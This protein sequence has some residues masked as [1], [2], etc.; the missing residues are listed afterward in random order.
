M[1]KRLGWIAAMS[2]KRRILVIDDEEMIL[3]ILKLSLERTSR[4]EVRTENNPLN[5]LRT[6]HE[7]QP[8]C[9]VLDIIMPNLQG[10]ALAEAIQSDPL[11]KNIPVIFLSGCAPGQT[12]G[13]DF[14]PKPVSFEEILRAIERQFN[15]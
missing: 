12:P 4:Y 14:L 5:A 8:D 2:S 11:T 1:W 10:P 3:R 7:F 15:S 9:I 13:Y 6:I